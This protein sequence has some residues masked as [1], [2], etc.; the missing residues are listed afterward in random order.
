M[1]DFFGKCGANCGHC[2]AYKENAKTD[3]AR[4]RGRDGWY[5]YLGFRTTPD[6]MYCD[7]CQTPDRKNPVLL[8]PRCINR[9][10]AITNGIANCAYCSKYPCEDLNPDVDRER[11][12][13]RL[14]TPMPEEDY[15]A[16]IEPYEGN[17]HLDTIRAL[18][19]PEDIVDPEVPVAK[20]RIVDFPDDLPFSREE[21][22]AFKAL[23]KLLVETKSMSGATYARQAALKKRT[24]WILKFLW[25]VGLFGELGNAYIAVDGEKLSAQK[26]PY[27]MN[28]DIVRTHLK[29]LKEFGVHC[30]HVPLTK[31]KSSWLT[32]KGHLRKRGWFI[33]MSF[34]SKAGGIT[35][36]KAFKSYATKLD[37]KYGKKAFRYFSNVDMQVLSEI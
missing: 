10:C 20:T 28:L 23:H 15:L 29:I 9:K 37:E 17:K 6:R 33:R 5:K 8:N 1:K 4:R 18:L 25:A 36:L 31:K 13:A 26:V 16:F 12:E 7:G 24:Q 30:E 32:S 3:E 34:D 27:W 19:K 22:S 21:T 2:P 35:T 14:G 11:I